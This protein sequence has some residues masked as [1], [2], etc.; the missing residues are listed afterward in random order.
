MSANPIQVLQTNAPYLADKLEILKTQL[1]NEALTY[2]GISN[3]NTMKR[4]RLVSEEIT[5][6]EGGT[7]ANRYSRLIARQEACDKINKMFGLD[8]SVDFREDVRYNT[9]MVGNEYLGG[10]DHEP[11]HD[12]S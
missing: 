11:L 7:L 5:R 1:W 3:T 2:L 6:N 10:V 9:E 4:E 12:R 8:I